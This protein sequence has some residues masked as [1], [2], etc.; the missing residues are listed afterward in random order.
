M[1]TQNNRLLSIG[2]LAACLAIVSACG[3]QKAH[4]LKEAQIPAG[5]TF[6]TSHSVDVTLA[7]G[8]TVVPAGGAPIEITRPDGK[9]VFRGRLTSDRPLHIK[10]PLALKDKELTA[11]LRNSSGVTTMKLPI[12]GAAAAAS[13][14]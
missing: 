8:K 3:R 14:N 2:L 12:S 10:V 13:F 11:T 1:K 5:F 6:R 4:S 9:L 7:A